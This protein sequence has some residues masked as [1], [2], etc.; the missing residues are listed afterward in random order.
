VTNI[1]SC[2]YEQ[3]ENK[4]TYCFFSLLEHLDFRTAKLI[5]A[6][7][8]VP[9]T[10][11]ESLKVN[12]LYGGQESNPD[13]SIVL[14]GPGHPLTVFFENKTWRRPLDIE[15]IKRHIRVRL[16][17]YSDH[18]LLVIT[19]DLE[20]GRGLE[21]LGDPRIHF[22]TWHHV[23][24]SAEKLAREVVD[25]KDQFLLTQFCD[26]LDESGEAWRAKMPGSNLL[27]AHAQYLKILPAEERFLEECR[28]LVNALRDD[29]VRVFQNEIIHAELWK[30]GDGRIG[31]LCTLS[32]APFEQS[33]LFGIYCDGRNQGITFKD[34]YRAEF[35]VF[36]DIDPKERDNLARVQNLEPAIASLKS[37]GFEFNF[38]KD[39]CHNPWRLCYWR[40][41]MSQ[42]EGATLSD[43]RAIFQAQL[44][45]LFES[46]FYRIAAGQR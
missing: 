3:P 10:E 25:P 41:P 28:R 43:V 19:T 33:L 37:Q 22:M 39:E 12:L 23:A 45:K 40:E 34:D 38:P 5:L 1:F 44:Q 35:A 11:Y 30:R 4:L 42:H 14:M 31:N 9:T 18:H 29:V 27:E 6:E 13:G 21:S 24:A 2:A 8:S 32:R 16:N 15:Q 36:F 17:T 20:H 26:Y 46:N 7:S